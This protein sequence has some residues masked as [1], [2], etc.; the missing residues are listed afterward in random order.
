MNA[1]PLYETFLV[2]TWDL[3]ERVVDEETG[4]A[5]GVT[6]MRMDTVEALEYLSQG[7]HIRRHIH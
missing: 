7:A 4:A 2:N 5:A 1:H 6:P 3:Q